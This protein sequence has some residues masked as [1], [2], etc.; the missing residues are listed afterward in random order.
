MNAKIALSLWVLLLPGA[1]RAGAAQDAETPA[2]DVALKAG[3][4]WRHTFV[5][6]NPAGE[7]LAVTNVVS[8]CE[9]LRIERRPESVDAGGRGEIEILLQPAA[10]GFL[11]YEILAQTAA[12]DRRWTIHASVEPAARLR[13]RGLYVTWEELRGRWERGESYTLVDVRSAEEYEPAHLPGA[14][15]VPLASVKT[16]RFLR[17]APVV[18]VDKG[19]GD[20]AVEEECERLRKAGF[21]RV[22]ILHGGLNAWHKAGGVLEGYAAA[23]PVAEGIEGRE[24]LAARGFDDWVVVSADTEDVPGL[25]EGLPECARIPCRPGDE[26][27]FAAAVRERVAALGRPARLLVLTGRGQDYPRIQRALRGRTD[28]V[29]FY[30]EGGFLGW[31]RA[32][33]IQALALGGGTWRTTSGQTLTGAQKTWTPCGNCGGR[34]SL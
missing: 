9:C 28:A 21:A 15:H 5:L 1:G 3:E 12:G 7:T 29:V 30:L 32:A 16:K 33:D 10:A 25:R 24:F 23:A 27:E 2:L 18:L 11:A 31:G 22:E 34:K 4:T 26:A 8:S 13:D 17:G 20:P 19:W 6:E 14:I